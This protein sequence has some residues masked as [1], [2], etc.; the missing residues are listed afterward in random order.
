MIESWLGN[1]HEI[2]EF[3]FL[4]TCPVNPVVERESSIKLSDKFPNETRRAS[5]DNNVIY[6]DQMIHSSGLLRVDEQ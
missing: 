1:H 6:I 4:E 3:Q 2:R 5:S